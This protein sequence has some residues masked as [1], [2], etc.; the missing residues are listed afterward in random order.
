MSNFAAE[1]LETLAKTQRI[2]PAVNQIECHPQL[3]QPE[4]EAYCQ[5]HGITIT[6][7]SSLKPLSSL[8]SQPALDKVLDTLVEKHVGRSK[9]DI[10]LR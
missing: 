1:H 3:L 2:A 6:A 10:L 9:A 5:R 4:L 8:A 7:Y